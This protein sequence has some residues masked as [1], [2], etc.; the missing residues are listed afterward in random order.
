MTLYHN[1]LKE[2]QERGHAQLNVYTWLV[3]S[4]AKDEDAINRGH[5][6]TWDATLKRFFCSCSSMRYRDGCSA[7]EYIREVLKERLSA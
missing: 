5:L 2:A 3:P 1:R 6:V 4:E 7:I